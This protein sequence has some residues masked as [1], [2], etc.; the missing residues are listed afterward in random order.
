VFQPDF[1][2]NMLT[3]LALLIGALVLTYLTTRLSKR[4]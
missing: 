4:E 2:S 1:I 3:A